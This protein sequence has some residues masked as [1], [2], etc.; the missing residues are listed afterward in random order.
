MLHFHELQQAATLACAQAARL[1]L[2]RLA[3]KLI[4]VK[5]L[6]ATKIKAGHYLYK[7]Y[8]ITSQY[9]PPDACVVWETVSVKTG[10]FDY[11]GFR[12]RDIISEINRDI[13][14]GE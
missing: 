10:E 5:L 8:E 2:S 14:T 9:Y 4:R 13:N 7:G 3:N 6:T 1:N 12:K 11:R